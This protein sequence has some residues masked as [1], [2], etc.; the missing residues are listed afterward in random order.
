MGDCRPVGVSSRGQTG[1][2]LIS[3]CPIAIT[4]VKNLHKPL[5]KRRQLS[6][7]LMLWLQ[8]CLPSRHVG[9][10]EANRIRAPLSIH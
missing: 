10:Y 1:N 6:S 9:A 8:I 2:E 3:L 4:V 7:R 5:I